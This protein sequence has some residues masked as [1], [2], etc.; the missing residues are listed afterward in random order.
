MVRQARRL[1]RCGVKAVVA[2]MRA[3]R[4]S[5]SHRSRSVK[6]DRVVAGSVIGD[7]LA[8]MDAPDR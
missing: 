2:M 3:H 7:E 4:D 6:S 1:V 5:L 8:L